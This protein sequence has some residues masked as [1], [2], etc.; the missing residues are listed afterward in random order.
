VRFAERTRRPLVSVGAVLGVMALAGASVAWRTAGASSPS[1][2]LAVRI[3]EVSVEAPT[4]LIPTTTSSSTTPGPP[5]TSASTTTTVNPK[6]VPTTFAPRT[7]LS[8]RPPAPTQVAA[9]PAWS[10]A[11]ALPSGTS[12]T[13]RCAAARQWVGQ[14]GL[15]LPSGWGFRCPG[16]AVMDGTARWGLACWNCEG[17]GSSWIAVDIDLIGASEATLRHVVAHETCHAIEYTTL[18]LTTE[19]TADLCAALHGAPRP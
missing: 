17:N 1:G 10:P 2:R 5:P 7:T 9:A 15:A 13:E 12:P 3:A 4:T 14:R 6:P 8:A 11:V 16:S 18:G 19:L